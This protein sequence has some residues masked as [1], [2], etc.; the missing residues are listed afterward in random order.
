[1]A[2]VGSGVLSCLSS[3]FLFIG[4]GVISTTFGL[5][6]S[7]VAGALVATKRLAI[8]TDGLDL[9]EATGDGFETFRF[10][11]EALSFFTS[12]L[13]KGLVALSA[14]LATGFAILWGLNWGI[15]E[16]KWLAIR[17]F[18][19][20][21]GLLALIGWGLGLPFWRAFEILMRKTTPRRD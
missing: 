14:V 11:F 1:M 20:V 12:A 18:V 5:L 2:V 9:V 21:S 4:L 17:V 16:T 6:L 19:G 8:L 15:V 7:L 10:R 3:Q 13:I